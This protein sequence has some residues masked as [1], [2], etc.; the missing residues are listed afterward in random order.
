MIK[1]LLPLL[2]CVYFLTALNVQA[3]DQIRI[4]GSSD[5]MPLIKTVAQ[6]FSAN[7]LLPA[8]ALEITGSGNGF[9]L[10]CQGIGFEH[11]DINVSSRPVSDRELDGCRTN[12]VADIT[13]I[14]IG[15]DA[16][17][18][19]NSSKTSRFDFTPSVLFTAL[20]AEV[21]YEGEIK[22]N[23]YSA[24]HEIDATLP[25]TPIRVIWL[26]TSPGLYEDFVKMAIVP[27]CVSFPEIN[28]LGTA[29][30]FSIC[31]TLRGGNVI[32]PGSRKTHSM[33]AWLQDNPT[34]LAIT[35]YGFLAQ[36]ANSFAGNSINGVAPT[37][38][39]ISQGAY[40]L[41]RPLYVYVK[42]NHIGAVKGL[43]ALL[44]ELTSDH[45]IGPEGYLAEDQEL[46][47]IPLNDMGRN[48]ARDMALSLA[49]MAR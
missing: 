2:V 29:K 16:I 22:R 13:E 6:T 24:W 44:Y 12:G 36:H 27:G 14:I 30:Q 42:P 10:F 47:F 18:L 39:H 26:P 23:P 38:E 3:R 46:G 48:Q 8:P 1:K 7:A 11:P 45:T 32:T 9:R 21:V 49:P 4:V 40:P 43:Q 41:V 17:V 31:H 5:V 19:I 33:I 37:V 20:A 25:D 15:Q 35:H 34:A 28:V